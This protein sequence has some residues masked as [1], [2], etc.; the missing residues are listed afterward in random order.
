NVLL[1]F[2]FEDG[3]PVTNAY[4]QRPIYEKTDE[5]GILKTKILHKIYK[6]IKVTIGNKLYFAETFTVNEDTERLTVEIFP[7]LR[8]SGIVTLNNVPLDYERL[9]FISKHQSYI[10]MTENGK[11]EVAIK[12]GKYAVSCY[13][14]DVTTIVD[15]KESDENKINFKSGTGIFEFEFPFS[16]DWGVNLIR[17][18]EDFKVR[19]SD[20]SAHD[21]KYE[22]LSN[23]QD[24]NYII[25][26]YS[27]EDDIRTNITVETTIKS[28]E[29]KKIKF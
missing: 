8:I 22:K 18:M 11:F 24:G 28:G 21:K 6:D 25:S 26:L 27:L 5:Q 16:C 14:I 23:V 29:T 2:V 12:P 15:L 9:V 17:K 19:I 10:C 4:V 1:T 3:S 13:R 7:A 20:V